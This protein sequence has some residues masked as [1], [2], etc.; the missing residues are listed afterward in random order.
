[1]GFLNRLR[2]GTCVAVGI[3]IAASSADV[4][5]NLKLSV[6]ERI[7]FVITEQRGTASCYGE[8]EN[9]V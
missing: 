8:K 7:G 3:F 1:M 2:G 9:V 4:K 6:Q 5:S